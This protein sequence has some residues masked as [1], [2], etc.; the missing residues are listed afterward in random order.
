MTD[1]KFIVYDVGI[2]KFHSLSI[3]GEN[4]ASRD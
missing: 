2:F 1:V 3:A 4:M